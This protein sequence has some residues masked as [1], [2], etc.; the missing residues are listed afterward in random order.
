MA[1]KCVQIAALP[2]I[3][4]AA[5]CTPKRVAA[6]PA[7]PAPKQNVFVLLPDPEG[8]PSGI[9]VKNPAGAQ[10]LSQAYRAIRVERFDVAPGPP[11]T[12]DQPEVRRLFGAALDVLPAPEVLFT[13]H[14]DLGM[15]VLNAESEAQLPAVLN[16]V[17]NAIRERRSTAIAVTGHTDTTADEQ[18]NYQLGL[19]RAQRVAEILAAQDVDTSTLFVSSHGYADLL[20]KT[21]LG[22]AEAR[23]RRVEIIV[24]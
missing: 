17:V 5:A 4:L 22:V 8:K 13:L 10:D 14:F 12:L 16:A 2:L 19:R 15:D 23:N 11:F 21:P 7:P 9:V 18:L 1:T 6:P 3:L 20:V 24:R